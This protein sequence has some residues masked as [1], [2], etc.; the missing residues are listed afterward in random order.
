[1]KNFQD[2][3]LCDD[4]LFKEV[5]R[6]DKLVIGFLEIVLNLKGKISG[7]NYVETE[8]GCQIILTAF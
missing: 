4:F 1:M 7:V 2:L 3:N 8:K 5:M 6:D